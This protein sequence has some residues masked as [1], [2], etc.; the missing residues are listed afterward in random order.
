[1]NSKH[2]YGQT[3]FQNHSSIIHKYYKDNISRYILTDPWFDSP[4]F[5]SWLPSFP[6][7]LNKEHI[8]ALAMDGRLD[9]LISQ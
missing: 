7:S 3:F 4:A 8:I 6:P 2:F 9:V 5:G 1:M